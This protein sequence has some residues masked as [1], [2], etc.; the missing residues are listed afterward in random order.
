MKVSL[1][2]REKRKQQRLKEREDALETE[3]K[4]KKRLAA[5]SKKRTE[6]Y[7]REMAQRIE[8]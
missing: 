7:K 3:K 2:E 8:D 5:Q 4:D 6:Q 1:E